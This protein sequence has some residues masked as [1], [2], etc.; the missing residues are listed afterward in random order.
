[1]APATM[2]RHGHEVVTSCVGLQPALAC[3]CCRQRWG[4]VPLSGVHISWA[5]DAQ[6]K[7]S[8]V[9]DQAP[10]RSRVHA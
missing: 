3:A 6:L 7:G 9:S 4:A 8:V 1:M 2:P 5:S 10:R